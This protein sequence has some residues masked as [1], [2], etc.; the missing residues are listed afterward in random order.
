MLKMYFDIIK[1]RKLFAVVDV[2]SNPDL[3]LS[4]D[5]LE[6]QYE[7]DKVTKLSRVALIDKGKLILYKYIADKTLFIYGYL[8]AKVRDAF[9][10]RLHTRTTDTFQKLDIPSTEDNA[11]YWI[12]KS[13]KGSKYHE[14]ITDNYDVWQYNG[15]LIG[16]PKWLEDRLNSY[17]FEIN[18]EDA[19]V[20]AVCQD[21]KLR[22]SHTGQPIVQPNDYIVINHSTNIIR[23][24]SESSYLRFIED[25]GMSNWLDN[26]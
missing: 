20:T 2:I 15:T 1:A 18:V 13:S 23:I 8:L 21:N 22:L 12:G 7:N 9:R 16:A 4:I 25:Y 3:T 10:N 19:S 24:L 17:E 26:H 5:L 6:P 11:D 14:L